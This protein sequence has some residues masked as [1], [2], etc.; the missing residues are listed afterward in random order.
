MRMNVATILVLFFL[1]S[2][3][4][5]YLDP[6]SISIMLQGVLAAVAGAIATWK[7]WFYRLASLFRRRGQEEKDIEQKSDKE[8]D[9]AK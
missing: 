4:N 1:P 5:A 7:Y 6:G 9:G 2:I 8:K 3:A